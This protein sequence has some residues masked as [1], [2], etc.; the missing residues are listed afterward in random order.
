MHDPG[1]TLVAASGVTNSARDAIPP[2]FADSGVLTAPRAQQAEQ[3]HTQQ[4]HSRA[5]RRYTS[6]ESLADEDDAE[7]NGKQERG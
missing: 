6:R 1:R 7:S 4:H 5:S 2:H 3:H